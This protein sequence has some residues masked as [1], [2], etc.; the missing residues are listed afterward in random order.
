[1][2]KLL[3]ACVVD[4][5]LLKLPLEC[6]GKT[7]ISHNKPLIDIICSVDVLVIGAKLTYEFADVVEK[8]LVCVI[9]DG[10]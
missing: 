6:D 1:L 4:S 5:E 8:V 2:A 10:E 7:H 3:E 9:L